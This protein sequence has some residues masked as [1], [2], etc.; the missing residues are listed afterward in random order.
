M[1]L[2]NP[3]TTC[4]TPTNDTVESVIRNDSVRYQRKGYGLIFAIIITLSFFFVLPVVVREIW[5][6]VTTQQQK[7]IIYIVTIFSFHSGIYLIANLAMYAIYV[8]KLPFFEKYRISSKS[9]PWEESPEK[10]KAMLKKTLK[11]N[12][13][14][15]LIIVPITLVL[16]GI[17]GIQM[18]MDIDSF[19]T[20]KEIMGQIVFFMIIEDFSFYWLH[21]LLHWK[22]IY[23]YIHKVHHEYNV[24]VSIASEYAHPLEFFLSNL[25]PSS[26]GPKILGSHVHFAT[27]LMWLIMRLMETVDGHSGYEFS[28]S[29]YRLLPLSGSSIYHNFHHSHNVGNYGSF[30]T[31]WDT[32]CGTN[33]I[34]Y[35]YLAKREKE[36]MYTKLREQYVW[37]QRILENDPKTKA[38][39]ANEILKQ[40]NL[41]SSESAAN[42]SKKND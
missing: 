6:D 23:P 34:Y 32:L 14:S 39:K 37:L 33:K 11:N 22:K 21:R 28:W 36:I 42:H 17:V 27:Y 13:I 25:I 40:Q 8:I 31:Y 30:F 12:A 24:T 15:H 18:R 35:R 5:P 7:T 29:P 3:S 9:W 41:I 26:L 20:Y 1:N 10:W 16:D 19:P 38:A 4:S 2:S